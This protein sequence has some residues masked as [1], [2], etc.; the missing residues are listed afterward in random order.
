M[1]ITRFLIVS[2]ALISISTINL[3]AQKDETINNSLVKQD[4]SHKFD[5]KIG[6]G[7]GFMGWGDGITLC[8]ENEF[9]YQINRYFTVAAGLG[10]GR[11][12]GEG[13]DE[14]KHHKD[15][16]SGSVNGFFSPFRNNRRNNFRVG[17]GYTY[18]NETNAYVS[19]ISYENNI[20][21]DIEYTNDKR[22]SHCFNVI[23]EDEF[24]IT[25]R[26]MIGGKVFFTAGI[27]E[28]GVISGGMVKFGVVL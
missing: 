11:S 28:G 25:T 9:N 2:A 12:L 16:L 18:I 17:I 22:S 27:Q 7:L 6:T 23:L 10:I 8:F 15:Y 14:W 5:L 21:Y 24:K 26:L 3:F 20:P 4:Y 19:S 13:R 1:K